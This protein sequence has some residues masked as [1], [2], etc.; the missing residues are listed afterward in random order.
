MFQW[1]RTD[2]Q[3]DPAVRGVDVENQGASLQLRLIGF[4]PLYAGDELEIIR[5]NFLI[6]GIS[7]LPEP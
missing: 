1:E 6:V 3:E 4:N 7:A 5:Q 2:R